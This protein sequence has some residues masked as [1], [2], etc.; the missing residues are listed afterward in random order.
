MNHQ[1]KSFHYLIKDSKV[2]HILFPWK[3]YGNREGTGSLSISVYMYM[4]IS[5]KLAVD[6]TISIYIQIDIQNE[7]LFSLQEIK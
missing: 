2:Y 3:R 4:Y 1:K 7:A 5:L 6:V